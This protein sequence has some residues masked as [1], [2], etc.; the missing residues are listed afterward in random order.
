MQNTYRT[1]AGNLQKTC[2]MICLSAENMLQLIGLRIPDENG[3]PDILITNP[4]QIHSS[5]QSCW[6]PIYSVKPVDEDAGMKFLGMYVR[7]N[8]D[9]FFFREIELPDNIV[10]EMVIMHAKNSQPGRND[11]PYVAYKANPQ[12]SGQVLADTTEESGIRKIRKSRFHEIRNSGT[13]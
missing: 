12:V 9:K 6:R 7:R 8:S 3:G 1:H 2:R 4:T 13:A 11:L 5:I 10:M